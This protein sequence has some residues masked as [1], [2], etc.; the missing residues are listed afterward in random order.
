MTSTITI[1]ASSIG[2]HSDCGARGIASSYRKQVMAAGYELNPTRAHVGAVVGTAVHAAA[3]LSLSAIVDNE[4]LRP[5]LPEI[6]STGIG[7]FEESTGHIQTQFDAIT[8]N[9][10]E[11]HRQ[12][13]AMVRTH[14]H[15]VVPVS[16][17]IA[18]EQRLWCAV[19]PRVIL[20]GQ[21]DSIEPGLIQ[22]IKTGRRTSWMMQ[23]GAYGL[24]AESNGIKIDAA[25]IIGI[26]RP[27]KNKPVELYRQRTDGRM[28]HHGAV[29]AVLNTIDRITE[30]MDRVSAG[31]PVLDVNPVSAMCSRHMCTAYGTA[32]CIA[33]C[34]KG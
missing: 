28:L 5:E 11:A 14:Y 17:P 25:E 31:D 6:E 13:L 22:D 27:K 34:G 33:T 32:F 30:N 18:V 21:P 29:P 19:G 3:N 2:A 10:T 8:P 23:V 7:L 1:R 20:T 16:K 4:R 24:L 15:Y 9:I 12:I 26:P